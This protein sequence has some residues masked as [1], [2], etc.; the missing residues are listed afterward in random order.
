MVS[1]IL[2]INKLIKEGNSTQGGKWQLVE[3]ACDNGK[4]ATG[5][6]LKENDDVYLRYN[7]QYK[8]YNAI[9][10]SGKDL[11]VIEMLQN[12]FDAITK[13]TANSSGEPEFTD[14][15]MPIIEDD[16]PPYGF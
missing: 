10:L 16:E 14:A 2:K 9:K 7:S 6:N 5:L 8:N 13:G 15:D 4:T 3:V 12:I 1:K 11:I